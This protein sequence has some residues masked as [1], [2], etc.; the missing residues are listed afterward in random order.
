MY[1]IY[2]WK[3]NNRCIYQK[4]PPNCPYPLSNAAKLQ[5]HANHNVAAQAF[6]AEK[7]NLC[8]DFYGV[9]QVKCSHYVN[10]MLLVWP[11]ELCPDEY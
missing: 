8:E 9:P 4:M 10:P 6:F 5:T 3:Q 1:I 2:L 7:W 11:C